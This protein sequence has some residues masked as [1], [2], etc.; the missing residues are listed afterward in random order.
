MPITDAIGDK[1]PFSPGTKN[2]IDDEPAGHKVEGGGPEC[3]TTKPND[4]DNQPKIER[5]QRRNNEHIRYEDSP[6]NGVC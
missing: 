2:N 6:E 5:N 3:D 4:P 1:Q